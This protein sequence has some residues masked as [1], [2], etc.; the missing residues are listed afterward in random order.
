MGHRHILSMPTPTSAH[1]SPLST[2]TFV[3]VAMDGGGYYQ[4]PSHAEII[5]VVVKVLLLTQFLRIH[6]TVGRR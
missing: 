1:T 4:P 5:L 6:P 3:N 2:T